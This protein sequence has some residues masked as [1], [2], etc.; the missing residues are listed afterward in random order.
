MGIYYDEALLKKAEN[1]EIIV[2][3]ETSSVDWRK[4]SRKSS[5]RKFPKAKRKRRP[6]ILRKKVHHGVGALKMPL[7]LA[8]KKRNLKKIVT[9]KLRS[10]QHGDLLTGLTAKR[11]TRNIS[12][13]ASHETVGFDPNEEEVEYHPSLFYLI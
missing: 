3:H 2:L 13:E 1:V 10:I 5:F 7:G 11:F 9:A 12:K 4:S 6:K 8:Q